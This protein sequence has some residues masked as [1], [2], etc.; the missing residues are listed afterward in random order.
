MTVILEGDRW[1]KSRWEFSED[2]FGRIWTFCTL[3][4]LGVAVYAFTT[5]N[6]PADILSLFQNP[7]LS[8]QR[9]AAAAG[10]RTAATLFRGLPMIFFLFIA[11]QP[12]NFRESTPLEAIS[13]FLQF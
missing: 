11:A 3:I 6:G 10:A 12:F 1:L 8:A 7:S 9:G 13:F 4:L 2:A 5:N